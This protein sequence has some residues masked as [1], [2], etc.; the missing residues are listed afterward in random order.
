MTDT[1]KLEMII[2]DSGLKKGYIAKT[3]SLSRQ[4]LDNKIKNRSAFTSIE[5][6]ALCKILN[7][8]KMEEKEEI[9]F[10]L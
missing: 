4:T 9:F 8:T 5:I 6:N 7:I 2:K 3:M 10:V 1:M